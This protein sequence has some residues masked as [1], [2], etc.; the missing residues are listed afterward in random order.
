[1]RLVSFDVAGRPVFGVEVDAVLIDLEAAWPDVVKHDGPVPRSL[2]DLLNLGSAGIH[3]AKQVVGLIVSGQVPQ[4]RSHTYQ[5]ATTRML[6]PVRRPGKIIAVGRNY[7]DHVAEGALA[8]AEIPRIFPKFPSCVIGPKDPIIHPRQTVQLDF[9]AELAVVIGRLARRVPRTR[10][11]EYVAGYTIMNDVSARDIQFS[12]PEQLTM[13]KN[14]RTFAPMGPCV[15]TTDEIGNAGDLDVKTWLNG[16]LMQS[17]NTK[18]MIFDVSFLVSFLSEVMDLEPGDVISTGTPA[19]VG[20]FRKPPVFMRPGDEIRIQ[21]D[22][23]GMLRNVIVSEEQAGFS[24]HTR[25]A[26]SSRPS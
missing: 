13:A 24:S 18:D 2:V 3:V 12:K 11:L 8:K 23:I 21:I 10:A 15:V 20:C 6:A 9:E 1:M 5:R 26:S 7:A 4:A 25:R 22:R 16:Q 19:G 17:A 14:F